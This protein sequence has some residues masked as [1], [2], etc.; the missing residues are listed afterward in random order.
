M[1]SHILITKRNF[2]YQ[3]YQVL[4]I[5][6]GILIQYSINSYVESARMRVSHRYRCRVRYLEDL[7][8]SNIWRFFCGFFFT[9]NHSCGFFAYMT[10]FSFTGIVY[11]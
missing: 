4:C 11:L 3:L 8:A 9:K 7:L 10:I 6:P 2:L 1:Y 5:V